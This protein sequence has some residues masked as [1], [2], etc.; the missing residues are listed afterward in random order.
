M[1]QLLP[2]NEIA[3]SMNPLNSK[4]KQVLS[5][6]LYRAIN[7]VKYNRHKVVPVHTF[8]SGSGGT[9]KSHLVKVIYNAMS[10]ALPYYCKFS[11]KPKV[12]LL[13]T[14]G[15]SAM[16]IGLTTI[17]YGLRIKARSKILGLSDKP[18]TPLRNKLSEMKLIIIDNLSMA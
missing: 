5:G 2:E 13:G 8:L 4:L 18:E 12:L 14:I 16:N 11:G 17:Y 1:L 15:I 9:D 10:N 6:S 7:Y 3:E